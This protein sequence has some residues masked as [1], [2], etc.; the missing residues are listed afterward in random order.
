MELMD[1]T[2]RIVRE[3]APRAGAWIETPRFAT[4]DSIKLGLKYWA[5]RRR[6]PLSC[7]SRTKGCSR[8][9]FGIQRQGESPLTPIIPGLPWPGL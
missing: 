2:D 5:D 8:T 4:K 7:T 1:E 9:S 6:C 3:V